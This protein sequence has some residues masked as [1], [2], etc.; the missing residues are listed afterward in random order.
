MFKDPTKMNSCKVFHKPVI[1]LPSFVRI[2]CQFV[3]KQIQ[4]I[5]HLF[6]VITHHLEVSLDCD[7]TVI[8]FQEKVFS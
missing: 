7:A 5:L 6:T 3:N 4:V 2:N 1:S 8:K